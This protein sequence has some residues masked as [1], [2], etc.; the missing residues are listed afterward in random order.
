MKEG[1]RL[2]EALEMANKMNPQEFRSTP[3]ELDLFVGSLI[4]K[5]TKPRPKIFYVIGSNTPPYK[6]GVTMNAAKR[7]KEITY[8]SGREG[9][10]IHLELEV[11]N[12]FEFENR[13]HR[14]LGS[15]RTV[16]EWFNESIETITETIDNE[17][18]TDGKIRRWLD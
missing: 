9:M 12:V 18:D 11:R 10:T 1:H 2:F 15:K 17:L 5:E 7:L 14:K 13:I 8:A 4:E 3:E 6:I 16:G